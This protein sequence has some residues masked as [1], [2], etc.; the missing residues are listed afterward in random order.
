MSS[1]PTIIDRAGGVGSG[2]PTCN[3]SPGDP[4]LHGVTRKPLH[5]GRIHPSRVQG[6]GTPIKRRTRKK[7]PPLSAP[8]VASIVPDPDLITR[9]AVQLELFELLDGIR[10]DARDAERYRAAR[11]RKMRKR[12]QGGRTNG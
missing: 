11:L 9:T 4:C 7:H 10:K 3:A 5:A 6:L 12:T 2:C 1:L 8:Q